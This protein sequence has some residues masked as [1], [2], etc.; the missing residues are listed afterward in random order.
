MTLITIGQ[1]KNTMSAIIKFM[2]G[3]INTSRVVITWNHYVIA[4]VKLKLRKNGQKLTALRQKT[5]D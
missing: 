1:L 3:I 4:G 2:V 5:V